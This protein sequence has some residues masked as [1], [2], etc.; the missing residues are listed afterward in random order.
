MGIIIKFDTKGPVLVGLTRIG[1]RNK[2]F[3]MYKFR[4][5]IVGADKMKDQLIKFNE[6]N[7]GPLFK[8]ANDPRVTRIGKF[9]RRTSIDEIPQILNV[10]KGE[11]SLV[12][13]RAHEPREVAQYKDSQ[14]QLLVIKPGI[15]GM[16]Q[17]SGR[18]NLKFEDE[19]RLDVYYI[20][21]WSLMLDFRILLKTIKVVLKRESAV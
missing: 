9:I 1:A 11:M 14:M 19:A 20:E 7:D 17:V 5:M 4:S 10:L 2:E 18:S 13:P 8:M 3:K 15:T 21:N 6:R 12:G 16:A